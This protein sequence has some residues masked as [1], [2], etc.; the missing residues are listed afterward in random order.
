MYF[1][2]EARRAAFLPTERNFRQLIQV[3]DSL[4]DS[5]E[6]PEIVVSF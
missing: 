3:P 1:V 2:R 4:Y 5:E 6:A